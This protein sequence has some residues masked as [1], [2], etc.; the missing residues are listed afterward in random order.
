[1]CNNVGGQLNTAVGSSAL[2]GLTQTS[3][4]D[5]NVAIGPQALY[6]NQGDRNVAVGYQSLLYNTT[7]SENVA[8]GN[9]CMKNNITGSNNVALGK[10]AYEKS[11]I[12][13]I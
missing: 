1:M 10:A 3:V 5:F 11:R 8:I 9:L 2:E 4:G 12:Q 7:G 13:A 6:S